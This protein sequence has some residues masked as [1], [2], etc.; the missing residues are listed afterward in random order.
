MIY[1]IYIIIISI[2]S[3]ILEVENY[4]FIKVYI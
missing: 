1:K 4:L 3:T 2:F